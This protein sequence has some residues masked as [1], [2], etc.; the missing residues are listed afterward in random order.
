MNSTSKSPTTLLSGVVVALVF[1]AV[2][3]AAFAALTPVMGSD[4]AIRTIATVLGGAYVLYLLTRS[5]ERSGRVVTV[6][7]W[8]TGAVLASLFVVSLPMLL[9]CHVAMIWLV[10]ALYFHGS[11]VTALLDL[12]V[13]A[14]ALAAA[15]WAARSSGSMFLIVWCFF[16]VQALF[17][18]LPSNLAAPAHASRADDEPFKRAYRSADA[19]LHRLANS[20]HHV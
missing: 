16:L 12:G 7:A 11:F 17:V 13:A 2:G 6:A 1:A 14:L 20:I 15:I 9:V 19:A 3:A 8:L 4:L 18:V 5:Q 10:R